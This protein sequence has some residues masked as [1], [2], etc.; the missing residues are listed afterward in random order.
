VSSYATIELARERRA[1]AGGAASQRT[2][3]CHVSDVGYLLRAGVFLSAQMPVAAIGVVALQGVRIS[4]L[5]HA[6]LAQRLSFWQ[7]T[8]EPCPA[9]SRTDGSGDAAEAVPTRRFSS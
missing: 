7:S 9:A 5:A 6:S 8:L 4:A 2:T 3:E 1:M